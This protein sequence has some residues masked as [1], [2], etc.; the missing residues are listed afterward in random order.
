MVKGTEVLRHQLDPIRADM[1]ISS[2]VL[3]N[4]GE[5]RDGA[6]E[7][8]CENEAKAAKIAWLSRKN[9]GKAHGSIVVYLADATS[10]APR[11]LIVAR[12]ISC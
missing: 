3:D 11:T 2:A 5:V 12:P 8:F 7:M 9:V 10:I 6:A 1:V 4:D